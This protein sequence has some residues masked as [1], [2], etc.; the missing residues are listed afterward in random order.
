MLTNQIIHENH[1]KGQGS[2]GYEA[3]DAPFWGH[4]RLGATGGYF[5]QMIDFKGDGRK[6]GLER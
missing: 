4:R 3:V 5:R 2:S 1:L 6:N